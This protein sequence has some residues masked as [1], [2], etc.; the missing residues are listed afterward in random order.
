MDKVT[1]KEVEKFINDNIPENKRKCLI[2]DHDHAYMG[3][4]KN[5]GLQKHQLY[6]M[7]PH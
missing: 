1:S 7:A 4:V 2:T 5:L 6:I 3:P